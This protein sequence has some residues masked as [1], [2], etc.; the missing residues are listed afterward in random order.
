MVLGSIGAGHM[1]G[2]ILRAVLDAKLFPPGSVHISSP[3]KSE[4]APFA[5]RGCVTSGSNAETVRASD[6]LLLATRPAQVPE[7]LSE[8]APL[9]RQK[10]VLSI[11]AG[12][13]VRSL[14]EKLPD[15]AYVL[16]VMP[17]LPLAVGAGVAAL[18]TPVGVPEE[19]VA[20][21]KKIF[22]CGGIVE[23]L[24]EELINASTS[25]G[26]SAVAYFFRMA[27]V[28]VA[29]AER[30]G[31]PSDAALRIVSQTMLGASR[32]LTE[33]GKTPE[34]LAAGVAVPGGTTE[35]AFRAF[36]AAGFDQA[37]VC[38]LDACR[39]RGFTLSR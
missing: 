32:M 17:N 30:N 22:S 35:A 37:L 19:F 27:S 33:S 34:E 31:I 28:M 24:D 9:T 4:L 13:T 20:A 18:A 15:D 23:M 10:C 14:K 29:W 25:L 12:V 2:A 38:G 6:I 39:E 3:V 7:V 11:A 36:D 21:A 26:G 8:I 1:G 16:R 5:E